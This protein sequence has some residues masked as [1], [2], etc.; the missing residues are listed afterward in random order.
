LHK[1]KNYV[2]EGIISESL[3]N[4]TLNLA[5]QYSNWLENGGIDEI[6]KKC[7]EVRAKIVEIESSNDNRDTEEFTDNF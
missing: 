4:K 7:E 5:E 1:L 2:E 3:F 6:I